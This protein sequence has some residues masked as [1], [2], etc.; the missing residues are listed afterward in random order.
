MTNIQQN[1]SNN[2]I[3]SKYCVDSFKLIVDQDVFT[4][5]N[6]PNEFKLIDN[7]GE[8]IDEF[9][10]NSIRIKYNETDIYISVRTQNN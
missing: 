5:I 4:S 7:E 2:Q 9:K 1:Q 6:I 10:K 8:I 3:I